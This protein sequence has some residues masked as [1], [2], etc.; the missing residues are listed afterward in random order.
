MS[1]EVMLSDWQRAAPSMSP[2]QSDE[3]VKHAV[4]I[5]NMDASIF[6]GITY[7]ILMVMGRT[8]R[9]MKTDWL[10]SMSVRLTV[11]SVRPQ[12]TVHLS[13][14]AYKRH[15]CTVYKINEI[16]MSFHA[17]YFMSKL[18]NMIVPIK[19]PID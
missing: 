6:C 8:A 7:I 14:L 9:Q 11:Q 19:L 15:V 1:S 13:T 18:M 3:K 2:P 10:N 17:E 4:M 16:A 12:A 5:A